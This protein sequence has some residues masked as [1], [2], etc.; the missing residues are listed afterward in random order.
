MVTALQ[1]GVAIAAFVGI[2]AAKRGDWIT[3]AASLLAM[4]ILAGLT[5][6]NTREREHSR[7]TPAEHF[8]PEFDAL[9]DP[10]LA[11]PPSGWGF[12]LRPTGS[13]DFSR[14]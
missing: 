9:V 5:I 10:T 4:L 7:L 8:R 12:L 3:F 11:A 13:K 2:L 6:L 14:D 1:I